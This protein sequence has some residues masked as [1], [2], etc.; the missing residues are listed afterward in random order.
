MWRNA[1]VL[2]FIG[3]LRAHNDRISSTELNVGFYGLDLYSLYSSI[4]PVL[5]YLD[6]VDPEGAK[7]ARYR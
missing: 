5:G 2:E 6:K 7:R 3:W 4:Q 1:H